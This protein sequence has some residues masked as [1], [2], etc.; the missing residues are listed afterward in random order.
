MASANYPNELGFC[1]IP[2]WK[3]WNL[4]VWAIVHFAL[5]PITRR[6]QP[7]QLC[8]DGV[9]RTHA[10]YCLWWKILGCFLGCFFQARMCGSLVGNWRHGFRKSNFFVR[11]FQWSV[12]I[13]I[14]VK[15][16]VSVL[17]ESGRP[18]FS[19]TLPCN[20][21]APT[22]FAWSPCLTGEKN[23]E[24]EFTCTLVETRWHQDRLSKWWILR[25]CIKSN[26][27]GWSHHGA[28]DS[29]SRP[30][31]KAGAPQHLKPYSHQQQQFIFIKPSYI[32]WN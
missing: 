12:F 8:L 27:W 6:C 22:A 20:S 31:S 7:S 13:L 32:I 24:L 18:S 3:T 30:N 14:I 16:R 1:L 9:S 21:S 23:R 28:H 10:I 2:I 17:W 29:R 11:S 19:W 15:T 5:F 26:T 25:V 4:S